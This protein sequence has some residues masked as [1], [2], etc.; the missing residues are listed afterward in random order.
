MFTIVSADFRVALCVI[1]SALVQYFCTFNNRF[2]FFIDNWNCL[3]VIQ[4]H[5]VPK[6]IVLK[7]ESRDFSSSAAMFEQKKRAQ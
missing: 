3:I 6:I 7:F 1:N 2:P 4:R 5:V